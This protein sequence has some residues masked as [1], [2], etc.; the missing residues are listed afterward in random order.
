M[1]LSYSK[2]SALADSG[3]YGGARELSPIT[4]VMLF[5]LL[6][7]WP[8][9]PE[10]WED[11]EAYSDDIDAAIGQAA[12]DLITDV[13]PGGD[14]ML[15]GTIMPWAGASEPDGW[16][17][18]DGQ[19]YDGYEYPLL[20]D[21]LHS[22]FKFT[23]NQFRTPDLRGR[24]CVGAGSGY[25]L[26]PRGMGDMGGEEEHGLTIDE[27]PAHQHAMSDN[28]TGG[29]ANKVSGVYYQYGTPMLVTTAA[30]GGDDHNNMQ[31][32]AALQYIIKAREPS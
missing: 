4:S 12:V 17:R 2:L 20:M 21:I 13:D 16:L 28:A 11:Y 26:T 30:G 24:V 7:M 19:L 3:A 23:G 10:Y 9:I 14:G 8:D 32:Y 1:Q 18:C 15:I 6:A 25:G 22:V 5:S 27:M 31:P 29:Q